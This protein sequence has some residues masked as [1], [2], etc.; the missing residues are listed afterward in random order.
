MPYESDPLRCLLPLL[1]QA[2]SCFLVR[3]GGVELLF[4]TRRGWEDGDLDDRRLD[5]R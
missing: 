1:L 3:G 5:G 4:G 2:A